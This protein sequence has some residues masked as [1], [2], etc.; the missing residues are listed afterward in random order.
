[1]FLEEVT[2]ILE[3]TGL[4]A[5]RLQIELTESVMLNGAE[6]AAETMQQ[7]RAR[8]VSIAIDDFGTGYSCL[9]Y[10]PKLPFNSLKIDRSFVKELEACAG[11]TAIVSSLV[12][13]AQSLGMN[14]IVEGIETTQQLELVRALG[15]TEA[16]GFLLG[17]PGP[18]PLSR[19]A[20][21]EAFAERQMEKPEKYLVF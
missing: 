10:L 13:L 1:G 14:V 15:I 7:L 19:L 16:Q 3:E 20:G 9:S 6:Q 21:E 2:E 18:D 17:R 5:D 4:A 8:G 11:S 12:M